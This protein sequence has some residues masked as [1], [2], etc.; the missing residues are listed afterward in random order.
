LLANVVDLN[1]A[2]AVHRIEGLL[3]EKRIFQVVSSPTTANP[4][5]TF[6]AIIMT[7]S[8]RLALQTWGRKVAF[9][10]STWGTNRY[11]Y[12]L[13]VLVVKDSHGNNFPTAYMIHSSED[14]EVFVTFLEH[15]KQLAGMLPEGILVDNCAAG[16]VTTS[17]R[18]FTKLY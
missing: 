1:D 5:G 18:N 11:G 2:M 16:N 13:T 17:A 4:N 9:M 10:D 15:V 3:A 7:G 8:G 6:C 12:A 14:T